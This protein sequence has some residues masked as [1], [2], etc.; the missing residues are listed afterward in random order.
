MSGG[1]QNNIQII[2]VRNKLINN[3]SSPELVNPLNGGMSLVILWS[4]C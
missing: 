3:P 1:K 2:K 4:G